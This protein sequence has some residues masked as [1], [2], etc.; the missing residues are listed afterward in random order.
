MC[1]FVGLRRFDGRR[2]EQDDLRKMAATLGHR[3]PDGA[4]FGIYGDVG[5]G[6]ARLSVID[7]AGSPQPMSSAS[8]P[9]HITYNGEIFNY[10]TVRR[11]L[12]QQGVPLRTRGDTVVLLETLRMK[13]LAGIAD[14]N[15]QFAF[16][17]FDESSGE[18]W[19]VRDRMGILP[20]YYH[21]GPGFIAFASEVKA[22]L[23]LIGNPGMDRGGRGLS[24]LWLG[25]AAA[26]PVPRHPQARA[27]NGLPHRA[28][29][30]DPLGSLLGAARP[31]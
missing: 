3:G 9:C 8:A 4:G 13:G 30:E 6:H 27:G 19:L 25:A 16:G 28:R 10:Q 17:Y 21:E 22:I 24:H 12:E 26:H 14:L 7:P 2:V 15:G 5:F 31:L 18:L 23:A 29:R 20:L 1:G 11:G